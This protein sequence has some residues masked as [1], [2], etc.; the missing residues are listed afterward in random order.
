VTSVARHFDSLVHVDRYKASIYSAIRSDSFLSACTTT[1]QTL[2]RFHACERRAKCETCRAYDADKRVWNKDKLVVHVNMVEVKLATWTFERKQFLERLHMARERKAPWP[3][4]IVS[5]DKHSP[6]DPSVMPNRSTFT[7]TR[8]PKTCSV[9]PPI[10]SIAQH[11]CSTGTR[12]R[13]LPPSRLPIGP[14]PARRVRPN[15]PRARCVV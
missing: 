12:R 9:I 2:T 4:N 11:R 8:T 5:Q 6:V 15:D 7:V 3:T 10:R 13:L 1:D 14:H